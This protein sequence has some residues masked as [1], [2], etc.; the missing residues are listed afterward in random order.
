MSLTEGCLIKGTYILE[1][2]LGRGAFGDVYRVRHKYLG[3]QAMK[4]FREAKMSEQEMSEMLHEALLLSKIGHPNVIRVFEANVLDKKYGKKGYFTMEYVAGGTLDGYMS[5]RQ[6]VPVAEAVA[7]ARQICA[8]VAVA[9][10]F[11]P[12]IIHRDLKPQN[13]LIGY[14][15]TGLRARVSDFGLAKAPDKLTGVASAAGSLMYKPPEAFDGVD[16]FTGDAF[17]IGVIFYEMLTGQIPFKVNR[18]IS[19]TNRKDMEELLVTSRRR[20]PTDPSKINEAVDTDLDAIVQKALEFKASDRY[21]D[22]KDMF[23]VISSYE[24]TLSKT[25]PPA[26]ESKNVSRTKKELNA[27]ALA[28]RYMRKAM[29]LSN[30]AS[31]LEEATDYLQKAFMID[32]SLREKYVH[33]LKMWKKGVVM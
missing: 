16:S 6:F 31:M 1:R 18:N 11:R 19:L 24:K 5:V 10:H 28:E 26:S 25:K 3:R 15:E 12:R 9:H 22:A 20:K 32:E 27:S 2:F 17:A 14:E 33:L 8:G 23:N 21:T 4:V 13:V 7:I 30:Q 29:K